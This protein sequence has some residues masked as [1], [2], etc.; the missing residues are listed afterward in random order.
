MHDYAEIAKGLIY[1]GTAYYLLGLVIDA[2]VAGV[3]HDPK[4][5]GKP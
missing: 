3:K 1:I 5:Q 2:I 4:D